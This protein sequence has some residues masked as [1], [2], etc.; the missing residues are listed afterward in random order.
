MHHW[1]VIPLES[2]GPV[3]LGMSQEEVR[4]V[5]GEPSH[6]E[7]AREKWGLSFPD[8][9]CFFRNAFQ[10][11]YNQE[12]RADFIAVSQDRDYIVTYEGLAVHTTPAPELVRAISR[13]ASFDE[14]Y[15][16]H[17]RNYWFPKLYLNL[18][19]SDGE[20]EFFDTM[21]ICTPE[22]GSK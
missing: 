9:D 14:S 18:F 22:F 7:Q 16:E 12:L 4:A 20:S 21:G 8:R 19:R 15:R 3:Q 1:E 10:V 11:S 6:T 5:L 13:Q 17:P 2:I